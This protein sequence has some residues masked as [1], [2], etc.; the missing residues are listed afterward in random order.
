MGGDR[1]GAPQPGGREGDVSIALSDVGGGALDGDC[2]GGAGIGGGGG[3]PG[4]G[5][6]CE[7]AASA[8]GGGSG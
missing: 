6:G 1:E 4:L 8:G 7:G 3:A 2:V 5:A